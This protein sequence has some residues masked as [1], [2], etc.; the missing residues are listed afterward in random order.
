MSDDRR[1]NKRSDRQVREAASRTKQDYGISNRR[2][3]NIIR[4]LQY[5]SVLTDQ[6]RKKLIYN[7]VD[8]MRMGR[9]DGKTEFIDGAVV[10]SLKRSIHERAGF[11]DGRSRMTLSHE[12]AHGVMHLG[13]PKFRLA[14]ATGSTNFS[15]TNAYESAEH[16][17]KVFASAFLIHD[18]HAATL[19]TPEEISE[20]FVV[21][22]EA[23]KIS[24]ERLE[25][26]KERLAA[27]ERVRQA[28]EEIQKRF[29][30]PA[31]TLKYLDEPCIGCGKATL[32]PIGIK[33]LCH[34]CDRLFDRLQDGD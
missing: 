34:S 21:S 2:P 12:L 18:E 29:R 22:L 16:Q 25:A 6:G 7:V 8:D 14:S 23:A 24:F 3:V 10:I 11:G 28:N 15:R 19:T 17:A 4:C 1:V 13:E 5:G 32:I 20:E 30:K 31:Q 26:E 27:A 9:V 33:V